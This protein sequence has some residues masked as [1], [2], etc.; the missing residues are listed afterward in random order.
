MFM[1]QEI[2]T[3]WPQ[4]IANMFIKCE[5]I[6]VWSQNTG[7]MFIKQE[8]IGFL[9]A[10]L[11]FWKIAFEIGLHAKNVLFFI[12]FK[13]SGIVFILSQASPF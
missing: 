3:V 5:I 1:K 8:I 10:G 12:I 6:I 11:S 2:L 7:S 13:G 4:N 9:E